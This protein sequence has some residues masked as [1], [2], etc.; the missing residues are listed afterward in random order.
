MRDFEKLVCLQV[1]DHF[2]LE[3]LEDMEHLRDSVR[4]RA[5]GQQDPLVEYKREGHRMFRHLLDMIDSTIAN[6]IFKAELK[7][8]PQQKTALPAEVPRS[9]TKVG[10][11]DPCPCGAKH[12]DGR[13]IKYKH[14]HGK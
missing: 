3:H 11:N 5:Y 4:L 8:Q 13:P 12:P 14:C 10:R 9:G 7:S 6:A 1:L 2:W